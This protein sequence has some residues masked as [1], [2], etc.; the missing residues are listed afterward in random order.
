MYSW[1]IWYASSRVWHRTSV[2]SYARA[3][4]GREAG[5]QADRQTQRDR[6]WNYYCVLSWEECCGVARQKIKRNGNLGVV[7]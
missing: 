5:K 4:R 2:S 6:R 7:K 1:Q 3:G